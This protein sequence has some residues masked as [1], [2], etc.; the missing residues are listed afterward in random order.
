[1]ERATQPVLTE[2]TADRVSKKMCQSDRER[3]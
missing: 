3:G 1:M 2:V